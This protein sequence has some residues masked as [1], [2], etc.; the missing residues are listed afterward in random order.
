MESSSRHRPARTHPALL[1]LS[2]FLLLFLISQGFDFNAR[3]QQEPQDDE[4]VRVATDLV[5]L[6]VTATGADNQYVHGLERTNF[7]V[8]EDGQEQQITNFSRE[9]T[10]FAAA[11]LLDVS[12]SMEGR[13]SMARSA[14]IRFLDGLRAEDT[15]AVYSFHSKVEQVQDFSQSRDL[16]PLAYNL[17]AKGQT[18]LHDAI[19]QAAT[20]L[21][22]RPEK[23]R[24]IVVLSDGADTRSA[25]SSDKALAAALAVN[26]TI[27][28]VDMAETRTGTNNLSLAAGVL[29]EYA[30]KSGGRFVPT[31]GGKALRD[32]FGEILEELSNQ[33]TIGYRPT[34]RLQDGRWRSIEV[35]VN[36]PEVKARTRR[37]YRL[38]KKAKSKGVARGTEFGDTR[39]LRTESL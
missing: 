27:Y 37:G 30:A 2:A 8:Y 39:H 20:D 35:K 14:A 10:P 29:R 32:A 31:P 26:A 19:V 38:M 21:S 25:A 17:D 4:I 1:P 36:R 13:I 6:N 23:R 15:A 5:V 33:Y 22:N 9:E 12:G 28:T 18:A 16:S 11:L 24:A 34:N 7:K 3:A